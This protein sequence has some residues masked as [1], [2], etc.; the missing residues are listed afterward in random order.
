MTG[1]NP[2]LIYGGILFVGSSIIIHTLFGFSGVLVFVCGLVLI[3]LIRDKMLYT[4]IDP[5]TRIVKKTGQLQKHFNFK[6]FGTVPSSARWV[7][8]R[9][10][11]ESKDE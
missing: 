6:G 4:Y 1:F 7:N 3:D 5:E 10:E 8:I 2:F 11:G 9:K